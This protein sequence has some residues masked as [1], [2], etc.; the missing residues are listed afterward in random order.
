VNL[1]TFEVY[2]GGCD[3]ERPVAIIAE[4]QNE[5]LSVLQSRRYTVGTCTVFT[6]RKARITHYLHNNPPIQRGSQEILEVQAV[7]G[8][9]YLAYVRPDGNHYIQACKVNKYDATKEN[10]FYCMIFGD[11][12]TVEFLE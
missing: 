4:N 11:N 2:R 1:Y 10:K 9:G 7:I 3:K 5:A 8:N 12:H 6:L